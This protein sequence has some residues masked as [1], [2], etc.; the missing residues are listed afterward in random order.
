MRL[1]LVFPGQGSQSVG[2]MQAYDGL[3]AVQET[4]VEASEVLNQDL[5]QL[6]THG[7]AETLNQTI[8]T[9]PVMLA[10]DVAVYRAWSALHRVEPLYMAGHSLGEYAALVAAKALEFK[11]AVALVRHRATLM[12]EALPAEA[13]AMAVI[14]GLDDKIVE[15]VCAEA[16]SGETVEAVNYN[17]PGQVV[18]AGHKSAVA[19][20]M[21]L[22]TER[23][24][25]RVMILPVS[26]PA[27]SSLM[28][29]AAQ[30]LSD[31]LQQVS[32]ARPNVPVLQNAESQAYD[33]PADI[34]Q[35]LVRQ[36]YSPVHWVKTIQNLAGYNVSHLI[37]CGPAK[38]LTGL[39]KRASAVPT[40]ALSDS[41]SIKNFNTI[42]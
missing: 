21:A 16:G 40:Y 14:L 35:A 12:Q 2:M 29:K 23:G 8:N 30:Q 15:A 26:V 4:F 36:L 1:A 39:N 31:Y 17:S 34:K 3:A 19:R 32:V 20:A 5:W 27:H 11:T 18:I 9:Q 42:T 7:P 13:G 24:A 28:A 10:A 37:E 6:V 33:N 25:K 41:T 38:V 22:A